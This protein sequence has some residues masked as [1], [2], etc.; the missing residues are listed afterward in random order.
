VFAHSPYQINEQLTMNNEQSGDNPY[1][2]KGEDIF[3]LRKTSRA[4]YYR[5]TVRLKVNMPVVLEKQ[6]IWRYDD[7]PVFYDDFLQAHYPFK[8][9]LAREIESGNYEARYR[10]KDIDGKERNVVFADEIDTQAEAENRLDYDGGAFAYSLYDTT[11]YRDRAILKLRK[12][13]DGDL[14]CA[15]IF[16]RPI[17]LDLNRSCFLKNSE[18][19]AAYGT[20]ALNV[21]GSYF[22][23][24]EINESPGTKVPHY[25]DWVIRELAERLTNKRALTVKTHRALFHARV[26]ANIK[27]KMKN[28]ELTGTINAFSLRYRKDKAFVA[29]FRI[30]E[31]GNNE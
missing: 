4:D 23:E 2:I 31:G 26:G 24:H 8:Y 14:Y 15:A 3:Y 21:T 30:T 12:E 11:T 10:I 13:N 20:A 5:N 6:E 22:S 25:E 29:S 16:G 28:E 27:L 19:V 17:I 18:A 1:L 7:P 9:P